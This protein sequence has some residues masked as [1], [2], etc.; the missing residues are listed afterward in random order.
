VLRLRLVA[1]GGEVGERRPAQEAHA[2]LRIAYAPARDELE[3]QARESIGDPAM[4]RHRSE[5]AE[6]VADHELRLA[7]RGD[8]AGDRVSGVLAVGVDHEH[9]VGAT[10][11]VIEPR[12]D[13]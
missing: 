7:R 12:A 11:E 2:V 1:S 3:E 8:E 5:I 10:G 9:G 13:C 4:Q 6:A